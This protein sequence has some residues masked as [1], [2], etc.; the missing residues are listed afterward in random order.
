M[1]TK[2]TAHNK[3]TFIDLFAGAGG[4]SIGIEQAGFKL[5]AATD[6]DHWSC[7]TLRANHKDVYI[8]EGD[9]TE[10]NLNDFE[11]NIQNKQVDLIVGSPPCQGFS[12]L[13]KR[14][15]DDPRN[16]LW[17]QYMRFVEHFKPKVFV[18]ENVPEI[19]KSQE[20]VEIK[21][22]AEKLGYVVREKNIACG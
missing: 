19:L 8:V 11:K 15:A 14:L 22:A 2:R 3:P 1:S 10:L 4:L 13:G 9:I 6:W 21:S 16:Q 5:L 12:A 17:R 7:E 18:V 20:F